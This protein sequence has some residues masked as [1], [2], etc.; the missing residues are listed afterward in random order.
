MFRTT[1]FAGL[2]LAAATAELVAQGTILQS[3]SS[4]DYLFLKHPRAG[5]DVTVT[6]RPVNGQ[7]NPVEIERINP[8]TSALEDELKIDWYAQASCAS[9]IK[10]LR[11]SG[12]SGTSNQNLAGS[13]NAIHGRSNFQSFDVA[14][15]DRVCNRWA[16]DKVA[17]C[18]WPLEAGNPGCNREETF[19]FDAASP[20]PRSGSVTTSGSCMSGNLPSTSYIGNLTLRCIL[21]RVKDQSRRATY[22]PSESH[23]HDNTVEFSVLSRSLQVGPVHSFP[24]AQA[25]APVQRPAH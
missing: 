3:Q 12:P 25:T 13:R 15:V 20:L 8:S 16:R 7:A 21:E 5:A 24:L 19:T 18:G 11:I 17:D 6:V 2:F 4:N 9:G 10:N 14:A 23:N 22:C 1:L